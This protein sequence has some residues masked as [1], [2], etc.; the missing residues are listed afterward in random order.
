MIGRV[1]AVA[2]AVP[3]IV[4]TAGSE[5]LAHAG[6][7]LDALR[8]DQLGVLHAEQQ[9]AADEATSAVRTMIG[10]GRSLPCSSP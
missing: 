8:H 2:A 3:A 7:Q 4:P 1:P 6:Q 10:A 9:R 5:M